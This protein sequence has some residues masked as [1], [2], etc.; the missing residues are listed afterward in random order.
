M[1]RIGFL[2]KEEKAWKPRSIADAVVQ[3]C[4]LEKGVLK[5]F[6]NLT[7]KNMCQ[8]LY[9]KKSCGPKVCNFIKKETLAQ[10]SACDFS[11]IYWNTFF[12]EHFM[13]LLLTLQTR[14]KN[15]NKKLQCR[16]NSKS[17]AKMLEGCRRRC[18]GIFI[19]NFEYI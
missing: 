16:L 9:F 2:E 15:I 4:S 14:I 10:M 13:W 7:E 3:M 18:S 12:M 19:V 17:I 6:S 1:G 11:E 8:S 5:N